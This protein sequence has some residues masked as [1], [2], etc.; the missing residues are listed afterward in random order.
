MKKNDPNEITAKENRAWE[1][2]VR[3][4]MGYDDLAKIWTI[5]ANDVS[6]NYFDDESKNFMLIRRRLW[7]EMPDLYQK[8]V[9]GM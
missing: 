7:F 1:N 3:V 6:W 9:M 8:M 2:K 5:F 4:Q